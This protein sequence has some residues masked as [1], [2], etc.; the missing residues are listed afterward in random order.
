[1]SRCMALS[2]LESV[3]CAR[4]RQEEGLECEASDKRRQA[5]LEGVWIDRGTETVNSGAVK[6]EKIGQ[7][8]DGEMLEDTEKTRFWEL[9]GDA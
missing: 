1:M 4:L 7:D 3:T 6:P 2:A 5:L 8:E 9:G